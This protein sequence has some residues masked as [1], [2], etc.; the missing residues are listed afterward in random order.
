MKNGGVVSASYLTSYARSWHTHVLVCEIHYNLAW[1]N[2]LA[3][4]C[5]SFDGNLGDIEMIADNMDDVVNSQ[6]LIIYLHRALQNPFHKAHV[7]VA[8]VNDAI[9]H[10]GID[11]AL[12]VA[13]ASIRILCNITYYIFWNVETVAR[14]LAMKDVYA[15]LNVWLLQ[16]CNEAAGETRNET[17]HHAFELH[18]WTVTD[19]HY[20]LGESE[21]MVEDMEECL[22][23][24]WCCHPFLHIIDDEHV[25]GLIECDEVVDVVLQTGISKLY[26]E[27]S[28][29]YVEHTLLWV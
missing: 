10:E 14:Y 29:T 4:A 25:D 18:W 8:V 27:C 13:D 12:K 15:Q 19:K 11:N 23:C 26:L 20:S 28:C 2:N 1:K 21:K 17:I 5:S 7:D 16:L 22:L 3:F 6:Y 24:L 9:C